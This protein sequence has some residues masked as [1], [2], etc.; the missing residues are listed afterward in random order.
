MPFIALWRAA[1]TRMGHSWQ[2]R[3]LVAIQSGDFRQ[4]TSANED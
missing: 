1:K 2:K 4:S 3:R